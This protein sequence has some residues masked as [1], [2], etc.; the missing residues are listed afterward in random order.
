MAGLKVQVV[1]NPNEAKYKVCFVK[2]DSEQSNHQILMGGTLVKN[3]PDIKVCMTTN[4]NEAK[5]K[6]TPKNFPK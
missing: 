5:I 6:I 1:S 4:K 3:S 2:Q